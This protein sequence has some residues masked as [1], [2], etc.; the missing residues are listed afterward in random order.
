MIRIMEVIL[1]PNTGYMAL[2]SA[3]FALGLG[4]IY[5]YLFPIKVEDI[6]R[7]LGRLTIGFAIAAP[8]IILVFNHLPFGFEINE[9]TIGMQILCWLGMY[10][11]LVLPFFAAGLALALVFQNY[12]RD[13]SRLYFFDLIAAGCACLIFIPLMPYFGP[14]GLI[15]VAA[16]ASIIAFICFARPSTAL[17][18]GLAGIAIALIAV[19]VIKTDYIEFKGH[20]NKRGNDLMIEQGKRL[21]VKWDPVSKL[22]ILA[23][24]NNALLFSIDG[25]TQGSWLGRFDGDFSYFDEIK[26]L[27]PETI[28]F[29]AKLNCPLFCRLQRHR[30]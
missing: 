8:T 9:Q 3:M 29:R 7:A 18:L 10:I 30:S 15:F 5:L 24:R 19:P 17:S 28:F 20:A 22:D 21:M 23:A 6:Q 11:A 27:Q 4:G 14:G 16:A 13:I 25:G 26:A 1:A 12:S 2:T